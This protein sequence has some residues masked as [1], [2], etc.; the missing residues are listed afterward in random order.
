MGTI[1]PIRELSKFTLRDTKKQQM[2]SLIGRKTDTILHFPIT[3]RLFL[4]T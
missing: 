2:K 1:V 4:T 3:K